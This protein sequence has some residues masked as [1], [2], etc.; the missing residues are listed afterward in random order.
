MARFASTKYALGISD[1]SGVAYKLRNMKKEW[2][3]ALVGKDEWEAKSPQLNPLKVVSDP[4]ALK[5]A[6]PDRT[7]PAV[8]VLL[9]FN[10]FQSGSSGVP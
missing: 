4:Q 10:P 2:T 5:N 3:G 1:R 9:F 7:E 8:E 6:R